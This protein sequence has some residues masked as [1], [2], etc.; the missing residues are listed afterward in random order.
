LLK[1]WD[2][3]GGE[4]LAVDGTKIHGQNARKKNF[5]VAKLKRHLDR[6]DDRIEEVM[7][8]FARLDKYEASEEKKDMQASTQGALDVLRARKN[9]YAAL[10]K[11]LSTTDVK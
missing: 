6:I 1:K 4:R 7:D 9:K 10:Q 2:L 5:N 3:I 8:E 11:Q